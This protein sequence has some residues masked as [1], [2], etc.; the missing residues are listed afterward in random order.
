M[1]KLARLPEP[2]AAPD[3]VRAVVRRIPSLKKRKRRF[4]HRYFAFLSYSHKDEAI[5]DW[6]HTEL[7]RFRV[8]RALAGRLTENG[9]IP[10]RLTP[11]FRDEQ[12]LAAADDLGEEIEGALASS[13]FLIVL[14][15]PNAARSHWTNAEIEVFKRARPDGC[16][17]AA[18]I[19][20][21]PFASEMP[22]R[23]D[24]ECFPPA[25]RQR[26]DRR[27]RPTGQRVEPL[28]A[29]LREDG[30]S[31][32][33][34]LLKL[35]AGMLGIGLDE[36]VQRETQRRHRR[37]AY[38]AAASLGGMAVT[39]TLAITAIQARD[40]ARDQ[41]R[42]AEGL[43]G[44]ML[45]DLKDKL[46]P[47]GRLDALDGV[48]S[49][50]LAYYQKQNKA[51]LTDA[52]LSQRSRALSL[53]AQVSYL[54]GDFDGSVRLYRE[55]MAGTEEAIRRNPDDAQRLFE[56]AQNVFWIGELA[57][58]R[59]DL[60]TAEA[61]AREYQ[62]L[63]QRMVG[64]APDNMRWRVEEQ[65]ASAELGI[66]FYN[67]RRFPDASRQFEQSLQTIGALT[68]ADPRNS[69][70][71]KS[72]AESLAWLADTQ[73]ALGDFR[74]SI[75]SRQRQVALLEH[76]ASDNADV[77]FA[78]KL[79]PA[80]QALG[81]LYAM[82][83]DLRAGEEQLRTAVAQAES[84]V[85]TESNNTLWLSYAAST[86]LSLAEVLL[87]EGNSAD[88][89]NQIESACGSVASLIAHDR[90]VVAWRALMHRCLTGRSQLALSSGANDR[91]LATSQRALQVS[92]SISTRDPI[93]DKYAIAMSYRL[94]GDARQ[95]SGDSAAAK[96]AWQAG[97]AVLPSGIAERPTEMG[98]RALLLQR[99]GREAEAK[100][101]TARLG[102]MGYQRLGLYG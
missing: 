49:R 69:D 83:G 58:N 17:L 84:L 39:S 56:H 37:L 64:L 59:G 26:Y 74:G 6:V 54:R 94:I 7:E 95:R 24:E 4:K 75:A 10:K 16:V 97:L 70:Y 22:G 76:L 42:E 78:E 99:L 67:Q 66:V 63:A 82:T 100:A 71:Q 19:A 30:E 89:S 68:T 85:S 36:L 12:E 5:A 31:R 23:E 38:V 2:D 102:A 40:A 3:R 8:P 9:V 87:A 29:D 91:A 92:Q 81:R 80:R 50:V 79:Q 51:E 52:A 98:G 1:G 15:S 73:L 27:G 93:A 60:R 41:R 47:V 32:R 65:N 48:G 18:I 11:I 35:I 101:L 28:A 96:R 86:R 43:I 90:S 77:G 34:G 20:G 33:I 14:C 55:A 57:R 88:A 25:L 21:E 45:G 44:F 13:Q 61:G 62:R 53:M 72:L 46:E